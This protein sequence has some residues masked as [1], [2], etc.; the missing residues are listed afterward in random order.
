MPIE[1]VIK[2]D[3]RA[4][5]KKRLIDD[6]IAKHEDDVDFDDDA[7]VNAIIRADRRVNDSLDANKLESYQIRDVAEIK[8]YKTSYSKP[9]SNQQNNTSSST[10]ELKKNAKSMHEDI[11]VQS[12]FQQLDPQMQKKRI[13]IDGCVD[14]SLL[15]VGPAK[16]AAFDVAITTQTLHEA[17]SALADAANRQLDETRLNAR[18]LVARRSNMHTHKKDLNDI[19]AQRKALINASNHRRHAAK[20]DSKSTLSKSLE[21]HDTD[22]ALDWA[23]KATDFNKDTI[24]FDLFKLEA[25]YHSEKEKKAAIAATAKATSMGTGIR[26]S[27]TGSRRK[28]DDASFKRASQSKKNSNDK[29]APEVNFM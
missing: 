28:G 25:Q 13:L 19:E 15:L 23:L 16:A 18:L 9:S 26:P 29:A 10:E 2:K 4:I 24:K 12:S 22:A 11:V 21:A 17:P 8:M 3:E 6:Y 20:I 5:Y 27:T 7:D 1:V 14:H